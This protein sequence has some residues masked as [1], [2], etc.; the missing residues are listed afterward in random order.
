MK[1]I[2]VVMKLSPTYGNILGDEQKICPSI[3]VV[4]LLKDL[5]LLVSSPAH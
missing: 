5:L 2:C 1:P 3:L 4:T